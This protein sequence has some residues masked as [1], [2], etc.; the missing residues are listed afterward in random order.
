MKEE[1][2]FYVHQG[3]EAMS[4]ALDMLEDK[5]GW[6]TEIA[7]VMSLVDQSAFDLL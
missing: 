3:Q 5:E 1:E 2:L 7:E 6:K 4:K